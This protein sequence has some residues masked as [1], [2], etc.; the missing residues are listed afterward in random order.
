MI[1]LITIAL[2]AILLLVSGFVSVRPNDVTPEVT[3]GDIE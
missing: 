2:Q 1:L 3:T